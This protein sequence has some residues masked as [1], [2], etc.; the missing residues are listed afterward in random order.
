M[1][2][3]QFGQLFCVTTFGE[4]HGPAMGVVI[5]GC[6]AGVHWRQDLMDRFLE[7]R[8]PGGRAMTS[9]RQEP[10]QVQILS[11]VFEGKTLGTPIAAVIYNRDARPQDYAKRDARQGHATDL[12]QSKFGHSD[13]R[14]SGRASGRET[15]S[16]VI[17]GSVAR[18]VVEQLVP[19]VRT[20]AWT[21]AI[22]SIALDHQPEDLLAQDPWEVDKFSLRCPSPDK[23][24]QMEDILKKAAESGESYGGSVALRIFGVPQGLGQPV[25]LKLKNVFSDAIM[26][27]GATT[28]FEIGEGFLSAGQN[29]SQFHQATQ[30]Y[31]GLR[32]GLATGSPIALRVAFKPTSSR[33]EVAKTG[34][35]DPCIVPRAVPVLE[36]MVWLVLVDQLL[37]ARLD[38]I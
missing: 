22:G 20:F 13:P 37:M 8:R 30:D 16:R 2:A 23:N 34:R 21:E 18:M 33:G 3:N 29:G 11:G 27:V 25:F 19:E 1:K 32:G 9:A 12:W 28:G 14:G 24:R 15:V 36:A 6:P 5:D 35:H 4:S 38:R 31:G 10:D 17:A 7:R 26:S